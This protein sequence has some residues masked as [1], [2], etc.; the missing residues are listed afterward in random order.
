MTSDRPG[1]PQQRL[2]ALRPL[3]EPLL[4]FLR[5]GLQI[6]FPPPDFDPRG[7]DDDR[8]RQFFLPPKPDRNLAPIAYA[9]WQRIMSSPIVWPTMP[10]DQ[11]PVSDEF[12]QTLFAESPLRSQA[13]LAGDTT[14]EPSGNW[15]GAYIR[16]RDFG[17]MSLVQGLWQIP[18]PIPPVPRPDTYASSA[19]VGLD[20][21]DPASRSMPQMGTAQWVTLDDNGA[22]EPQLYAWWQWWVRDAAQNGHVAI[23]GIRTD[24][25]DLI[26]A[27]VQAINDV[28][29][30]L[31][32]INLSSH[33]AFPLWFNIEPAQPPLTG[34]N[35][36]PAH[37]EGR[38]A[39]WILERP[40]HIDSTALYQLA[41]Y[42]RVAFQA[43]GGVS[44][45]LN[46]SADRDLTYA[47]LVR[48]T[49][50]D[51]PGDP[52]IGRVV[53]LPRRAGNTSIDVDYVR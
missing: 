16:P 49:S 3:S 50:W 15:S 42:G 39:E 28:T 34:P 26:Y 24:P 10:P 8:L 7:A 19:W 27:Q 2:L 13:R 29:A 36:L 11:G 35:P 51:L 17:A 21:H 32:L 40:Q 44:S 45:S 33:M 20:G 38:T 52:V 46:Q 18:D 30:S 6:N 48:M 1:R 37:I 53:S 5:K 9:T 23:R 14:Q 12:L 31:F 47:R 22:T 4:A 25:R 43:C 41:N